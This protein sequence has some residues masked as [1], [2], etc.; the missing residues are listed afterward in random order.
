M[1]DFIKVAEVGDINEGGAKQIDLNG[2]KI[3]LFNVDNGYYAIGDTCS[4]EK[5]SLSHG[6]IDGNVVSC[7]R[8]GARFNIKTGAVMS[9][10]AMFPVKTHKVKVEGNDI[11]VSLNNE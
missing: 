2:T 5:A 3:A 1:E 8:H 11:K 4:H 9:L 10:P 7:P 6:E